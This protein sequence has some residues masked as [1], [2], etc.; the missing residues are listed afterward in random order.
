MNIV[1]ILCLNVLGIVYFD[2]CYFYNN[3]I[4]F[5]LVLSLLYRI[6]CFLVYIFGM[7]RIVLLEGIFCGILKK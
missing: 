7:V 4:Y 3:I 1:N 5:L 2:K 6:N